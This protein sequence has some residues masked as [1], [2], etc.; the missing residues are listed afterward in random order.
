[1][2][3]FLVLR[4]TNV[5]VSSHANFS[6]A[7]HCWAIKTVQLKKKNTRLDGIV[8][9]HNYGEKQRQDD[10]DKERD[11]GVEVDPG[12]PPDDGVHSRGRGEGGE[13]IVAVDE[14]KQALH[15]GG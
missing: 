6:V 1:M 15:G 11:E 10:V 3:L 7:T 5:I 13:H 9:V 2:A 8:R 12:E 4:C 14:G